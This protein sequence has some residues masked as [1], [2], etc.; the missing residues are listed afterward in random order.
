MR[1]T[2]NIDDDVLQAAREFARRQGVTVGQIVSRL[3]RRG[4]L[5][6]LG[7]SSVIRNGVPVASEGRDQPR[8]LLP[9]PFAATL[10]RR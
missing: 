9:E 1:T 5:E 10:T 4:V 8:N 2:L 7:E 3:A 6:A